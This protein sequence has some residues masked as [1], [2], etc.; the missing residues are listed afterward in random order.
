MRRLIRLFTLMTVTSGCSA[1][2]V[3]TPTELTGQW[4]G[5]GV[6]VKDSIAASGVVADVG[7][8]AALFSIPITIDSLGNFMAYGAIISAA[9]P[10]NIGRRTRMS[11]R[12]VG[13]SL[14]LDLTWVALDHPDQFQPPVHFQLKRGQAPDWSGLVCTA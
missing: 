14:A 2:L 1:S 12:V 11:G 6:N 3:T 9:Y 10:P 8:A 13:N 5:K 4:G 7:C